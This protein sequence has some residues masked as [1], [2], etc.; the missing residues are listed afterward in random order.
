MKKN[1]LFTF[2]FTLVFFTTLQGFAQTENS[3]LQAQQNIEGLSIYPNPVNNGKQYIYI[4]SKNNFNKKIEIFNALGK[5]I[6]STLLIGKELNI[7]KL[8][9]GV[10]ILKIT[11]EDISE[12]RKLVIK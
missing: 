11:E 9:T 8:S 7:A 6:L 12:T 4:T 1:Y 2:I 10:Y 5:Q 3:S